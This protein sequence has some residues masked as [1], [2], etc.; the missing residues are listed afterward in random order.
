MRAAILVE[1]RLGAQISA[2]VRPFVSAYFEFVDNEFVTRDHGFRF[3][4]DRTALRYTIVN[5]GVDLVSAGGA[6]MSPYVTYLNSHGRGI[7]FPKFFG[8]ELGF[9]FICLP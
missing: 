2:G 3:G 4:L 7:E 5:L 1:P 9:G 6:I 8:S